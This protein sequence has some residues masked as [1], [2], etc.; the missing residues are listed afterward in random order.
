MIF[1]EINLINQYYI[2]DPL[3]IIPYNLCPREEYAD[4]HK[5]FK[6]LSLK[7]KKWNI[8]NIYDNYY[9]YLKIPWN[10]KYNSLKHSNIESLYFYVITDE[11]S[12]F[13]HIPKNNFKQ[14]LECNS[15]KTFLISCPIFTYNDK[16]ITYNSHI[17]PYCININQSITIYDEIRD[18][19]YNNSYTIC[20]GL[21]LLLSLHRLN[22][23]DQNLLYIELFDWYKKF[24]ND[25]IYHIVNHNWENIYYTNNIALIADLPYYYLCFGPN[26]GSK[27]IRD[28]FKTNDDYYEV[29]SQYVNGNSIYIT[30]QNVIMYPYY[31][32]ELF[33][34]INEDID[35][36]NNNND[37]N[38]IEKYN[39]DISGYI[40]SIISNKEI[41]EEWKYKKGFNINNIL[42][43]Q[44]SSIFA[45]LENIF[46]TCFYLYKYGS[47][48]IKI[49]K[50]RIRELWN[51]CM[52][53]LDIDK[54][55][56]PILFNAMLFRNIIIGKLNKNQLIPIVFIKDVLQKY[57][58]DI[59]NNNTYK[60]KSNYFYNL[61]NNYLSI[62]V[63]NNSKFV[64]INSNLYD[65]FKDNYGDIKLYY[66][67]YIYDRNTKILCILSVL[68]YGIS[69][70]VINFL[71]NNKKYLLAY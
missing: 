20:N 42:I 46:K 50:K 64:E 7:Q 63:N 39:I 68:P 3:N 23:I 37:E 16:F 9:Y 66:D 12:I 55:I 10:K 41:W 62:Q 22:K 32:K 56:V 4:P 52:D 21:T 49:N 18:V 30:K 45:I 59:Y 25:G 38:E 29:F 1:T 44:T 70:P 69:N 65:I 15:S 40:Q 26:F 33:D 8:I 71:K 43:N 54:I 24:N 48:N 58:I 51:I 53:E 28:I 34:T 36:D 2:V 13:N 27:T 47:D 31:D 14:W 5:I 57:N 17:Y 60:I 11:P 67:K 35:N 61:N 19:V 6:I